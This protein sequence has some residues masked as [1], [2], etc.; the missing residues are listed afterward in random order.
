MASTCSRWLSANGDRDL[1]EPAFCTSHFP[2]APRSPPGEALEMDPATLV[3]LPATAPSISSCTPAELLMH[4]TWCH[5]P[6]LS[7][8]PP[9]MKRAQRFPAPHSWRRRS[10]AARL[11]LLPWVRALAHQVIVARSESTIT[12]LPAD[13]FMC[14]SAATVLPAATPGASATT[15]STAAPKIGA[16]NALRTI[17]DIISLSPLLCQ[18]ASAPAMTGR[19]YRCG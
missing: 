8:E 11:V 13:S 7:P 3:E 5:L 19:A 12:V 18:Q 10:A 4:W 14:H 2:D 15:P 9:C 1:G 16:I 6:L 17:L